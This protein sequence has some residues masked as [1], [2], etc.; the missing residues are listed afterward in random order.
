MFSKAVMR[1]PSSKAANYFGTAEKDAVDFSLGEPK[2]APPKSVLNAYIQAIKEGSNRYAPIQGILELR[3]KIAEK[4][5]NQNKISATPQEIIVTGG[6]SEAISLS[7]MSILGGGDEV[8]LIDPNYPV[9]SAMAH[10]CGAKPVSLLLESENDFNPDLEKLKELITPKTK[11]I[12][13]NTPH[14]PTGAV[15]SEKCLKAISEIF[16][17]III[18]DEVYENFTYGTKHCSLASVVDL[19]EN[20]I[21]ISS[22]SKTYCMC[23]WRIGY[24]HA[25]KDIISQMLKLKMCLSTCTSHPC[26]KAAIAALND[27]EFP[28]IIKKRFEERRNLMVAGLRESGLDFVEPAGAFYIFP[29]VSELGGGEKAFELFKKS[30]VLTMPGQVFHEDCKNYL[31]FSFAASAE[32]IT[33]GMG[34]IKNALGAKLP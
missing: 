29:D 31:R 3:E 14:N 33:K 16:S 26:Q 1:M 9:T 21:T 27:L 30:G 28:V 6:A 4:L 15:F 11:M 17:S 22:F 5:V 32:E 23:G 25:R 7:L 8:I 18:A 24:L 34:R 12:V 20:I 19:P 2:D 13:L 10:F